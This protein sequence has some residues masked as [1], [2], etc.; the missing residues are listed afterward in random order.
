MAHFRLY[1]P[2]YLKDQIFISETNKVVTFNSTMHENFVLIE[3]FNTTAESFILH[4]LIAAYD[5]ENLVK[6]PT[7]FKISSL[8]T[9][10]L[11]TINRKGCFMDFAT[12]N[13]GMLDKSE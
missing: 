11:I 2:P 5:F 1:E 13:T 9:M 10:D 4:G 7:C 8:T 6:E 12:Y 3:E